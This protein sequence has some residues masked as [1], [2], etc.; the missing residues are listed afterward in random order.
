MGERGHWQTFLL[1]PNTGP[2][3]ILQKTN[4]NHQHGAQER[5]NLGQRGI[6]P[7]AQ[8]DPHP[9]PGGNDVI[10]PG[11]KGQLGRNRLLPPAVS[12]MPLGCTHPP[13]SSLSLLKHLL[14][15]T[16]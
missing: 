5:P 9:A 6:L 12:C 8:E 2:S 7:S 4:Q 11:V 16:S 1:K 3:A 10:V 14:L 13:R 15:E